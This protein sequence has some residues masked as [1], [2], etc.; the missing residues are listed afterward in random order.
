MRDGTVIQVAYVVRDL[1]EAMKRHMEVCDI[2]PWSIYHFEP[3]K[4]EN[5]V[6]RGKPATH[7]CL[8]AVT[9]FGNGAQVELMQPLT[10]YSIYDE[11]L[12]RKGE[13]FHHVKLYY[14]DCAKA[15]AEYERRGYPVM[16]CGR[17]DEDE[18]YYLDTE[19][20]FGYIVELGNAG[21]IRPAERR[22]P[23]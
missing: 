11:H 14:A 3:G 9:P 20:D 1:E 10:G 18:H 6:Y 23:E 4:I 16:Q 13:G 8:I 5:Y 21:R 17:I 19:K 12:E 2:G 7:T 15:V 22:F